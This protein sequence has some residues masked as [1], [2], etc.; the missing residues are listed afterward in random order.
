MIDSRQ[1]S[2]LKEFLLGLCVTDADRASVAEIVET[3][4]ALHN[5]LTASK[6]MINKTPSRYS[7]NSRKG[8]LQEALKPFMPAIAEPYDGPPRERLIP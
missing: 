5:V 3:F 4:R 2:W 8:Q 1:I 7:A 6:R